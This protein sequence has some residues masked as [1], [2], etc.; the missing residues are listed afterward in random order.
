M[1]STADPRRNLAP[2]LF[3]AGAA[4]GIV[5]WLHPLNTCQD[6]LQKWGEQSMHQ[7]WVAM[8]QLAMAGF[9]TVALVGIFLPMLGGR[10]WYSLLGG[11]GFCSGFLIHANTVLSHSTEVSY[12]ARVY[13]G[14]TNAETRQIMRATAEALLA[15]V[16]GAW[17]IAAVM[18]TG[19]G[20]LLMFAL[21]REGVLSRSVTALTMLLSSVWA[22]QS[23]GII[24][25]IFGAPIPEIYHWLFLT[26]WFFVLGIALIYPHRAAVKDD[27]PIGD[28]ISATPA[29][30]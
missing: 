19:G 12:L 7:G 30:E 28:H 4:I 1:S 3:I 8:H 25:R 13:L 6:W 21:Y 5:P 14:S 24:R 11:A 20:I 29:V 15:Y 18:V 27:A 26:A 2:L 10:S 16:D 22:A 23:L 9:A 17:R